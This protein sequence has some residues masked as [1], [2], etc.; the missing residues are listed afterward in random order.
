MTRVDQTGYSPGNPGDLP[1]EERALTA[2]VVITTKNRKVDLCRA[3]RSCIEQTARAELIVIDDGS[4]DGTQ[5]LVCRDFPSVRYVR[6]EVSKGYIVQRNRAAR[7]ASGKVVFSLDDDAEFSSPRIVEQTLRDFNDPSI[8]AV[9]VPFIN[10][11]HKTNKVIQRSPD[12]NETFITFAFVGTAHAVRRDVFLAVGGYREFLF[13]QGEE[14]DL[15]IRMLDIQK[16]TRLG[17][18]DPI[19]HYESSARD[20]RRWHVY[21]ARN[22]TLF[23]WYNVPMPYVLA[24]LPAA[25]LKR[26]IYG[27]RSGRPIWMIQGLTIGFADCAR[28][29]NQRRP[30]HRN[31]YRLFRSLRRR[32]MPLEALRVLGSLHRPSDESAC[33]ASGPCRV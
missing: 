9:A 4:T 5:E 12:N 25:T 22:R 8:A 14:E 33:S 26:I 29:L 24:H 1:I 27:F 31:T 2:T 10:I 16:F 32:P 23:S 20:F 28:Q 7:L 3:L 17:S 6:D 18:A 21:A 19:Y 13:H 11:N 30:V 15:C